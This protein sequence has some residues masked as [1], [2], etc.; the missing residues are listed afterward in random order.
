MAS[1]HRKAYAYEKRLAN[2]Y[3]G[4]RIIDQSE[5]D[6]DVV[7]AWLCIE[8]FQRN[9]PGY[10][11]DNLHQALLAAQRRDWKHLPI[12]IWREKYKGDDEALVIMRVKDFDEWFGRE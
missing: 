7:S 8:G 6:C 3:K 2:R 11:K 9:I 1:P 12:V 4:E 5:G 10:I